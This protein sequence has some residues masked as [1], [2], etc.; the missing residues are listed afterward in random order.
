MKR[1]RSHF[2]G[3]LAA[4]AALAAGPPAAGASTASSGEFPVATGFAPYPDAAIGGNV[5]PGACGNAV[6]GE[7]QGRTGGNDIEACVGAGLSFIGPSIGQIAT[8]IGPTT[9]SPAV[10]G[11]S[12]VSAGNVAVG[13]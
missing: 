9:I 4:A 12:I 7:N 2:V 3:A 11:G 10:V 13:P 1:L 8:V 5:I 6:A